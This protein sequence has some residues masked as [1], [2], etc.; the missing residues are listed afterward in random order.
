MVCE[1]A[2]QDAV[3]DCSSLA[4]FFKQLFYIF[5]KIYINKII[6]NPNALK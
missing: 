6:L 1:N 2:D 5:T 3:L 4:T